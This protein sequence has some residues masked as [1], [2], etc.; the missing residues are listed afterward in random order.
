MKAFRVWLN[1]VKENA[2]DTVVEQLED[3]LHHEFIAGKGKAFISASL[4]QAEQK[5][6]Q[7]FIDKYRKLI[8]DDTWDHEWLIQEVLA[9]VMDRGLI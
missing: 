5:E 3:A 9:V 6:L 7:S 1:D 2:A 4:T 8:P